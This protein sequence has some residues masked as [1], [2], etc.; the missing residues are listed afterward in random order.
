MSDLSEQNT[1]S[2]QS[3]LF[4]A[5][6]FAIGLGILY[7]VAQKSA[8]NLQGDTGPAVSTPDDPVIARLYGDVITESQLELA[9]AFFSQDDPDEGLM[10]H[11]LAL[12]R[13]IQQRLLAKLA[14]Q[15]KVESHTD[16][17]NRIRFARDM[18]LA[19]DALDSYLSSAVSD[20]EVLTYYEQEKRK[21]AGQIQVRA[22]QIVL[23]DEATA[24]EII[25]RLDDGEAFAT[26]ALAYSLD[27][28]S[29]E[30]GGDLGYL[31]PDMLD[32][33]LTDKIFAAEDGTRINR[34]ETPQ[35]WHVIEVTGRRKAPVASFE[36][37]KDD[38][39][40]LLE[41]QKLQSRLSELEAAG[42]LEIITKTED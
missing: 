6:V 17:R 26:L 23:P 21:W 30:S 4:I 16:T 20:D 10:S 33:L 36:D 34:L 29:R 19:E 24:K 13:L 39:R 11:E 28:A 31:N 22:R 9:R 3:R 12:D 8:N 42:N 40:A 2:P 37:R 32:P 7:F 14:Q 35:G 27:R 25:R 5:V 15:E 38:I 18:I 41:A 1:L